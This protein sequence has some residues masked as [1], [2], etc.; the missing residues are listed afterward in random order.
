M[1]DWLR[2]ILGEPGVGAPFTAWASAVNGRLLRRI[3]GRR[4]ISF[5]LNEVIR[6]YLLA[7]LADGTHPMHRLLFLPE[8]REPVLGELPGSPLFLATRTAEQRQ[9]EPTRVAGGELLGAR[10]TIPLTPA[11]IIAALEARELCPGT[12]V[13]FASLVFLNG[14]RCV[15]GVDQL[16]YLDRFHAAWANQPNLPRSRPLD[17]CR[18]ATGL[19][20]DADGPLL[21]LDLLGMPHLR[22]LGG[23]SLE[24]FVRPQ[25][26]RLLPFR[27]SA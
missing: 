20:V 5:D 7:V 13:V 18:L 9:M 4:V 22:P 10:L 12:L 6:Q 26:S 3:L 16:E 2:P 23:G 11:T 14:F 8:A 15:G 1:R 19:I 24:G 17:A 25:L 21:P 27:M